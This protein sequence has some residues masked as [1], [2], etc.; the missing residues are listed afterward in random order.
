[1]DPSINGYSPKEEQRIRQ[2][3]N[4]AIDVYGD[5][6]ASASGFI[7]M[8]IELVKAQVEQNRNDALLWFVL[9]DYLSRSGDYRGALNAY[10]RVYELEPHNP[11]AIY[12]LATIY[13]TLSFAGVLN[14]PRYSR[15]AQLSNPFFNPQRAKEE[16]DALGMTVEEVAQQALNLFSRLL[17]FRMSAVEAEN[18]RETMHTLRRRFP[19]LTV[20]R[21]AITTPVADQDRT[22]A[23]YQLT[24]G[25]TLADAADPKGAKRGSWLKWYFLFIVVVAILNNI[26]I[27]GREVRITNPSVM[28]IECF[29]S[30]VTL[31]IPAYLLVLFIRHVRSYRQRR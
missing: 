18:V 7:E 5:N 3:L 31:V 22:P 1:M 23:Q 24:N 28:A 14:D 20:Q 2:V 16:L 25:E 26:S 21:V 30:F 8:V 11:R 13:N 19:N 9:A 29:G 17:S 4:P 15:L 27:S 10:G 12:G 6:A